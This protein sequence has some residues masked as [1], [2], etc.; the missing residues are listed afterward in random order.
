[1]ETLKATN[2]TIPNTM[3]RFDKDWGQLHK[4]QKTVRELQSMI[5]T[6]A[7]LRNSK[8]EE[9]LT[10][11]GSTKDV[12]H[13]DRDPI[14]TGLFDFIGENELASRLILQSLRPQIGYL[15]RNT[16]FADIEERASTILFLA[17]ERILSW[18]PKSD[19]FCHL[20]LYRSIYRSTMTSAKKW[21]HWE[22]K[23]KSIE[24]ENVR[25]ESPDFISIHGLIDWVSEYGKVD[26]P[27]AKM[28][29]LTRGKY[30][31]MDDVSRDCGVSQQT[32]R[33]RRLRAENNI[34]NHL[35]KD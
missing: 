13:K 17:T 19:Q 23:N 33:Q 32:L 30:L 8:P 35:T 1:M 26:Q 27:T 14:L 2:N 22:N 31:S 4:S 11:V 24:P 25:S 7:Y 34:R 21:Y 12:S 20:S 29:V 5:S 16:N 15:I 28:I 10:L 9:I 18:R 6:N 3:Q